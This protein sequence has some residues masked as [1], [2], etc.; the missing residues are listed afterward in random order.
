MKRGLLSRWRRLGLIALLGCL[1]APDS[2]RGLQQVPSSLSLEE[3]IRTARENNPELARARN[4]EIV[5]DWSVRE[6]YGQ[7]LPSASF[8]TGVSWQGSGETQIAGQVTLADLGFVD[9]PSYYGSSYTLGLNYSLSWATLL[10]PKQQK[11]SR[12]VT[13]AQVENTD[14]SVVTRVT[15]GY[16][17]VWRQQEAVRIA[18]VQLEN[19]Q[20]NLRLAQGQLEVGQV[21][22]IDVGQAEVQVGRAE[23]ALLQARNA[24]TTSRMRLLQLMGVPVEQEFAVSTPFELSPPTWEAEE[25]VARALEDNPEA[26]TLRNEADLRSV[27]VSSAWSSYLPTLSLGAGWSGFTREASSVDFQIA[28]AQRQVA[29]QI[30]QCIRTNDLYARLADPLPPM[31]CGAIAFTDAQ[32]AAIIS[33]NDQFPTD[34]VRS[35]PRV[36]LTVSIPIFQG[37]TRQRA[38]EQARVTRA[39]VRETVRELELTI[40]ADVAIGLENARTAY[41]SAQLEERNRALAE[42]QLLLAR[43]RYQVGAITFVELIDA[44]TVFAQAE[45]DLAQA[46]YAYH[47]AVTNLEA[48]VGASL[49]FQD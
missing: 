35:P 18:Q 32:R 44:Q 6:A 9:Q 48:L 15:G 14:L 28:Q 24:L 7:L 4:D 49:R 17:D 16:I 30:A 3:A 43:E 26:R 22:P 19:A 13:L 39:D 23:V 34:F 25:L 2:A 42:Q 41:Q 46:V 12:R 38:L 8:S 36:S 45:V 5:A 31:D 20:L 10:G 40:R 29:S 27:G 33:A 11:A 47:D 21:T 37:F 1:G